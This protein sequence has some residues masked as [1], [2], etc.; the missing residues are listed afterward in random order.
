MARRHAAHDVAEI[1]AWA[2][3][4]VG[5]RLMRF[6]ETSPAKRRRNQAEA[7]RMASEKSFALAKRAGASA[8]PR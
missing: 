3:F 8:G 2:P 5:Q 4:V 6:A 7:V 1:A